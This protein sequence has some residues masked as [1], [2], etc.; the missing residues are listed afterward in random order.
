MYSHPGGEFLV[1]GL[2]L[3]SCRRDRGG[4]EGVGPPVSVGGKYRAVTAKGGVIYQ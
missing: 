1:P 3:E 4:S 2:D